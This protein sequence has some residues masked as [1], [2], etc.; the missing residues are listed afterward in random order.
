LG[1]HRT[2]R[3]CPGSTRVVPVDGA[4][5]GGHGDVVDEEIEAVLRLLWYVQ[6]KL[7][8]RQEMSK[9]AKWQLGTWAPFR[10]VAKCEGRGGLRRSSKGNRILFKTRAM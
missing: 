5:R 9:D 4:Q 2:A 1:P 10:A 3:N 6:K 7:I 8:A